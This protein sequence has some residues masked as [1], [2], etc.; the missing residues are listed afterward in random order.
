MTIKRLLPLCLLG[1]LLLA[2]CSDSDVKEVRDWMAK[3]KSETRVAVTPISEPKTFVPYAYAVKDITDPF[4]NN[5]LL[6][7]IYE[8]YLSLCPDFINFKDFRNKFVERTFDKE[9]KSLIVATSN[10]TIDWNYADYW[11]GTET[12][13]HQPKNKGTGPKVQRQQ[14]CLQTCQGGGERDA[15]R[16]GRHVRRR[17]APGPQYDFGGRRRKMD[18]DSD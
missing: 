12:A 1:G 4:S 2:G 9:Y 11:S 17:M 10:S 16:D 6:E 7:S 13:K 18:S 14:T 5:K 3:V 15:T 8:E